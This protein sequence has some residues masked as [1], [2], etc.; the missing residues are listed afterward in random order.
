VSALAGIKIVE[1]CLVGGNFS[2]NVAHQDFMGRHERIA[3]GLRGW[4]TKLDCRLMVATQI[5]ARTAATSLP[6][7]GKPVPRTSASGA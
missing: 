2:G 4:N 7:G 6:F 5:L 3:G 1:S